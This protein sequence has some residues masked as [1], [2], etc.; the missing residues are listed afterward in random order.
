MSDYRVLDS[1]I[2]K[3]SP[4]LYPARIVLVKWSETKYS[5]H[6]QVDGRRDGLGMYLAYGDYYT[7]LNDAK[8]GFNGRELR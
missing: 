4:G 2:W 7:N 5:T 1:K 6:M 3:T 8:N